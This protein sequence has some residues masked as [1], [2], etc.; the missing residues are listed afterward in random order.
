MTQRSQTSRR[1]HGPKRLLTGLAIG[2]G[3]AVAVMLLSRWSPV[4]RLERWTLDW[5]F[6]LRGDRPS[7]ASGRVLLVT[8]DDASL[9][10]LEKPLIFWGPELSQVITRLRQLKAAVIGVD[11]LQPGSVERWLPGHDRALA[12]ALHQTPKVV[13]ISMWQ[14][15]SDGR[16]RLLEPTNQLKYALP[17]GPA[18]IGVADLPADDDDFVR[19]Q[20]LA[21]EGANGNVYCFAALV[22]AYALDTSVSRDVTGEVSLGGRRFDRVLPINYVGPPGTFSTLPFWRLTDEFHTDENSDPKEAARVASTVRG[23]IVLIGTDFTGSQ[24]CHSTPFYR[25]GLPKRPERMTGVEVHANTLATLLDQRPLVFAGNRSRFLTLLALAA[26]T[27][28]CFLHAG[29]ALCGVVV[30]A[31]PAAW[32]ALAL[33]L[34]SN[35]D[36]VVD[37]AAPAL[38]VF[39]NCLLMFAYRYATEDR[40]RRRVHDILGKFVSKDVADELVAEGSGSLRLGGDRKPVTVLFAD[41]RGFTTLAETMEEHHVVEMLN[42]YFG[43]M[44]PIIFRHQGTLD[45]FIGDAIMAVFG[46]PLAYED[47]ALRAVRCALE[48]QQAL[49]SLKGHW[50]RGSS[51]DFDI[52]VGIHTG[53]AVA[54]RIGTEDRMEYT[55]IG[56]TVNLA[57]RIE[58]ANKELGTRIL[59]SEETYQAVREHVVADGPY[60]TRVK[61]TS[62]KVYSVRGCGLAAENAAAPAESSKS[63]GSPLKVS[64]RT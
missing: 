11:L 55:V 62:V 3:C 64:L 35:R 44:V 8:I 17:H 28:V 49:E 4:R 59:I 60:E 32:S 57:S 13:L 23:K 34:F 41:I 42:Q 54:G 36:V 61:A 14:P 26:L 16:R 25:H 9:E 2:C 50:A 5:R 45:K 7:P 1:G 20:I 22:A 10:K 19:S 48:M 15:L 31:A 46:A 38:L 51:R 56:N 58:G 52:G 63:L 6:V 47:H 30:L 53:I 27:G 24:D 33:A 12:L 29:P 37:V 39:L 21:Q 43:A 18:D 40:E